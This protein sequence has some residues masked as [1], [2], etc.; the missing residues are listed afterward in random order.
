MRAR[1]AYYLMRVSSGDVVIP[2]WMSTVLAAQ[3]GE[4]HVGAVW[5]SDPEAWPG[6]WLFASRLRVG[7]GLQTW[8]QEFES[9]RPCSAE[10][11]KIT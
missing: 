9:C 11:Y 4:K 10:G 8:V 7:L 6:R 1:G 5:T 2:Q 3:V